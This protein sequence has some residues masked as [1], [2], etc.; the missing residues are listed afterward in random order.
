MDEWTDKCRKI[1]YFGLTLHYIEEVSE[2]LVLN[3]RVLLIREI[4]AEKKD[5]KYLKDKMIEYMIEFELIAYLEKSVVFVSDRGPSIAAACRA[6]QSTHCFAHMV[7]NVVEKMLEK[8][9]IVS[10]VSAI[11]KYFKASGLNALFEQTLKSFV[12]T[13]WNTVYRMLESVIAHWDEIVRQLQARKAHLDDL[14]SI[15]LEELKM[16]RDFLRPFAQAILESEVTKNSTI[17]IVHPWFA[18]LKAHM[19]PNRTDP[20]MIANLKKIGDLY[21]KTSVQPNIT[22]WHDLAVFFNPLMKSLK[23]FTEAHK[24]RI[25][26]RTAE[27]M[28]NFMPLVNLTNDDSDRETHKESIHTSSAMSEFLDDPDD[29]SANFESTEL[30]EYKHKRISGFEN[31]LQWWQRNKTNFPRLYGVARFIFSIPASSAGPER[32][33]SSAGR[34]VHFRPNMRAEMVDEILFLKSNIDLYDASNSD[35]NKESEHYVVDELGAEEV[36]V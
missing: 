12:S 34:L 3:N 7:H 27:L 30:E 5:G 25:Y 23:T 11:V 10:A 16:M 33:F 6:F 15:S 17:D 20:E 36:R 26:A 28:D 32:L 4:S 19:K 21:W 8:N 1:S 2:Q 18:K 35:K 22:M 24:N 9:T 14:N 13:R 31:P 29:A